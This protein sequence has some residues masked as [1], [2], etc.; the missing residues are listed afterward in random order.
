MVEQLTSYDGLWDS[1]L[2]EPNN[3]KHF[4]GRGFDI[5]DDD[6]EPVQNCKTL[7]RTIV[8]TWSRSTS[9]KKEKTQPVFFSASL[10]VDL[11]KSLLK[12]EFKDVCA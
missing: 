5:V 4:I 1:L 3:L 9:Q 6:A 11:R 2:S 8:R 7:R 10:S 12:K